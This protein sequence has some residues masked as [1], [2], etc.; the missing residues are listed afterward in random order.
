LLWLYGTAGAGKSA[1]AQTFA[2]RYNEESRLGGSFFFKRAHPQ[3]GTWH[4][5]LATLAYQLAMFSSDLRVVIQQAVEADKLL[6][7]RSLSVQ[8]KRLFILALKQITSLR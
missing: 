6:V 4:G 1:I 2:G 3:R 5:L 8:F 7:G